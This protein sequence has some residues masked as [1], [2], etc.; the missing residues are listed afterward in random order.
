MLSYQDVLFDIPLLV[1]Y[2][3]LQYKGAI[4]GLYQQP[5]YQ[6]QTISLVLLLKAVLLSVRGKSGIFSQLWSRSLSPPSVS[7]SDVNAGMPAI[8]SSGHPKR[9]SYHSRSESEPL[10]RISTHNL[11][12]TSDKRCQSAGHEASHLE[13][14]NNRS[15]LKRSV[16]DVSLPSRKS[17]LLPD[18]EK[19]RYESRSAASSP[20]LPNHSNSTGRFHTLPRAASRT[21]V[22]SRNL[23]VSTAHGSQSYKEVYDIIGTIEQRLRNR[24]Q[25]KVLKRRISI[26]NHWNSIVT[27]LKPKGRNSLHSLVSTSTSSKSQACPSPAISSTSTLVAPSS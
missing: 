17:V 27:K 1:L 10:L 20:T 11:D 7:V 21:S 18:E 15:E 8:G 25:E 12:V 22:T 3:L 19:R 2:T 14:T 23:L 26:Q 6:L 13:H 4:W 16:S 5:I 24:K 9:R